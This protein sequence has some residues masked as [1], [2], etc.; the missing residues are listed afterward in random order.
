MGKSTKSFLQVVSTQ[1]SRYN[2]KA[3]NEKNKTFHGQNRSTNLKEKTPCL[4]ETHCW[5]AQQCGLP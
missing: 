2:Q 5:K 4:F 1:Y 3:I